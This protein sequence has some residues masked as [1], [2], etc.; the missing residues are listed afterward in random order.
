[1]TKFDRELLGAYHLDEVV[2]PVQVS[3]GRWQL[4]EIVMDRILK[5]CEELFEAFKT[6]GCD[7]AEFLEMGDA[8]VHFNDPGEILP[9][10]RPGFHHVRIREPV[11]AHVK[12]DSRQASVL[13]VPVK[14]IAQIPAVRPTRGTNVHL[15]HKGTIK[16][17]LL[18]VF[19][20]AVNKEWKKRKERVEG[21][22]DILI[23]FGRH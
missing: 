9:L 2:K 19:S 14:T 10:H 1:M 12:F 6:C 5:W 22:I 21:N 20:Y 8:A 16:M 17:E 11:E 4:E 15:C 7:G 23:R 3:K 13:N 18:M